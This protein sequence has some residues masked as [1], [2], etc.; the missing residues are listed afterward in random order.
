MTADPHADVPSPLTDEAFRSEAGRWLAARAPEFQLGSTPTAPPT[1]LAG[2]QE[3]QSQ[4]V[5]LARAWQAA[6][7]EAGWAG[8][9]WPSDVGGRGGTVQQERVFNEEAAVHGISLG[10]LLISLAMVA[11]T[12]LAH[13]TPTQKARHVPA[14]LRGE[15]LWCQ[16]YSEP[17]AGSDLAA[18]STRAVQDDDG[19][20]INGQ[21]VWTSFAVFADWAILLARTNPNRPKHHGISYFLLDMK[22]PGVE[23]RPLRE[24]SGTY[25]F[26]EVFLSDVRLPPGSL[27][28]EL[29]EGWRVT[30]T[31]MAAERAM[32]GGGSGS[33][34]TDLIALARL[35]GKEKDPVVRQALAR[36]ATIEYLLRFLALRTKAEAA[37][38]AVPGPG[39][40]TMKLLFSMK[41]TQSSA[42]A[43]QI[44][45]VAGT[46]VGASAPYDGK[47]QHAFL[48]APGLRLGGGTDEVQRNALAERVLGL[49]R[50]PSF[51]R[52]VPFRSLERS[53]SN[54]T[55][56]SSGTRQTLST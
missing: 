48:S 31:T 5:A 16:L 28:G 36:V 22:T 7:A 21:K 32:I 42:L 17:G 19:W 39:A 54:L 1:T 49:P 53:G 50:E 34:V 12:L 23:V 43:L 29:D 8:I 25:H 9:S 46:L 14:I 52:D 41:A 35:Y 2:Y 47:W 27:V 40:S 37:H 45:G 51:D 30:H 18:L 11:P 26:N 6:L 10:P 15:E 24:M 13:G 33:S 3:R 4:A 20:V 38:G 55:P 56:G 44:E